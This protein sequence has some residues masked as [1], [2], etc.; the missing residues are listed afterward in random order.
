MTWDNVRQR[1]S[2][3]GVQALGSSDE[4]IGFGVEERQR[5]FL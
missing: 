1:V 2:N 3:V 5:V 4:G